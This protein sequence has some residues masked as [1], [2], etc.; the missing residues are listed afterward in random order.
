MPCLS[1]LVLTLLSGYTSG[2]TLPIL[3]AHQPQT[4]A[5]SNWGEK[6]KVAAS[7]DQN[8][9]QDKAILAR[10]LRVKLSELTGL[11]DQKK[12]SF[13]WDELRRHY[14]YYDRAM[15]TLRYEFMVSTT[16]LTDPEDISMAY[17]LFQRVALA[18]EVVRLDM[19][20]F[21][22]MTVRTSV[23]WRLVEDIVDGILE[24][25]H[26]A[27]AGKGDVLARDV[28]PEEFRCVKDSVSRD[29]R[30][31]QILRHI[32]EIATFYSKPATGAVSQ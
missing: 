8:Q 13:A 20:H 25:L 26:V 5:L 22:D 10:N 31:F 15:D 18:L 6:V 16:H 29:F 17:N 1:I 7:P 9:D 3:C 28:F 24:H 4:S 21:E 30:D 32:L 2:R 14:S 27:L 19:D 12:D 11:I 23:M